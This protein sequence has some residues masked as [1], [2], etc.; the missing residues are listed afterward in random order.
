[1]SSRNGGS[2]YDPVYFH[3]P[4]LDISEYNTTFI[5]SDAILV[6]PSLALR[7]SNNTY[8]TFFP[9]GKWIHLRTN[10]S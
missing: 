7:K 5:V 3:F 9:P 2:C 4:E 6:Q 1:M 10:S 8:K